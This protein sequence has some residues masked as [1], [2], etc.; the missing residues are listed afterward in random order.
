MKIQLTSLKH[1]WQFMGVESHAILSLSC[2]LS[3]YFNTRQHEAGS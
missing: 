2:L 1:L 3:L